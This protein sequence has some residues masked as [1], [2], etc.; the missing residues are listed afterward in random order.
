M[1]I[2]EAAERVLK[3]ARKPLHV[4]EIA[5]IALEKGL[6]QT[7]GKTPHATVGARLYTDINRRKE[8]SPFIL[9][10]PQTF[11]LRDHSE[12]PP[13]PVAYFSFTDAAERVLEQQ[14]EKQ[15]MHYRAI[16]E[17]ALELGLLKTE[18]KTPEATMYAV[19]L[20][21]IRQRQNRGLQPRFVKHG[22][23]YVGLAR[24]TPVG[25]PREIE[26]HN[27]RIRQ[28]LHQKLLS[29]APDRFEELI[30]I[31]LVEMGFE[32]VDVTPRSGDGGIDVHGTL[33]I[34]EVIRIRMAVQVKRWKSGNNVQAPMVQQVRGSLGAHDQGLIITT[35]NFSRG[36]REEAARKDT[37]PV[38]LM[39]GEQLTS[40]LLEHNIGVTRQAYDLFELEEP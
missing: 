30:S 10:A 15:P 36:A 14:N 26:H 31:L 18:G 11:G 33:V 20:T 37:T 29:M 13:P 12:E 3:E 7:R 2:R 1:D 34:G 8:E 9:V 27:S 28:E 38:G 16:T 25:L 17:K 39:N 35:S 24:W 19:V 4:R 23:G 21:E 22:R 40:L 5:R 6:W 32:D